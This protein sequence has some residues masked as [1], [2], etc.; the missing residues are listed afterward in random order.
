ML[1]VIHYLVTPTQVLVAVLKY[2]TRSQAPWHCFPATV[3]CPNRGHEARAALQP[4]GAAAV[5][6]LVP[7]PFRA[8]A[9]YMFPPAVTPA[10]GFTAMYWNPPG[11]L[12]NGV[13]I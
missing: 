7:A 3:T 2:S 6:L 10:A 1:S 11:T 12:V 5:Q 4:V 9:K 8:V 13:P